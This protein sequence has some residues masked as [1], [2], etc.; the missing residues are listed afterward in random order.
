VTSE[1][2]SRPPRSHNP[3]S[4][5]GQSSRPAGPGRVPVGRRLGAMAAEWPAA[6]PDNGDSDPGQWPG[7]VTLGLT[8]SSSES[9]PGKAA[10]PSPGHPESARPPPASHLAAAGS[11]ARVYV[12]LGRHDSDDYARGRP[13]FR[14]PAAF[15]LL[16][17]T[18]RRITVT[19]TARARPSESACQPECPSRSPDTPRAATRPP[20]PSSSL[21]TTVRVSDRGPGPGRAV[22]P[23]GPPAGSGLTVRVT[24][25]GVA[26]SR[27]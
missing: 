18:C 20:S 11:L 13:G 17:F 24:S 26:R 21:V 3:G 15:K 16:V 27:Y 23:G 9:D 14:S 2:V 7:T 22:N 8:N 25:P 4:R 10:G 6:S 19:G 12:K 1:S 5:A